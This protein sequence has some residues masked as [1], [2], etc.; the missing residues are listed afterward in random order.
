MNFWDDNEHGEKGMQPVKNEF[1]TTK[2]KFARILI[3]KL[4]LNKIMSHLTNDDNDNS[5][6]KC[7]L[8]NYCLKM[9]IF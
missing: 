2:G 1:T 7:L 8:S 6:K 4:C 5:S 3:E 9:I